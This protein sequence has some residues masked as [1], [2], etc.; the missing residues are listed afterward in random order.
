[1]ENGYVNIQGWMVTDYGLTGDELMAFAIIFGFSQDG[2]GW[3][4]GGRDYLANWLGCSTKKVGRVLNSL[5]EKGYIERT[6]ADGKAGKCFKYHS[7]IGTKRPI[8]CDKTADSMGQNVPFDRDKTSHIN[9]NGDLK[10]EIKER[11]R[12]FTPP[13]PEEAHA[14]AKEKDY[15]WFTETDAERFCAYWESRG[16]ARKGDK[17]KSWKAALTTW[18]LKDKPEEKPLSDYA[19][20]NYEAVCGPNGF[21]QN[22]I[23]TRDVGW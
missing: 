12:R 5:I 13:T 17:L 19:R 2:K 6:Q 21:I 18:A 14:Y 8:Q 16:W 23:D 9:I 1:M 15:H 4:F 22:G 10:E 11:V 20:R 3:Y 7:L